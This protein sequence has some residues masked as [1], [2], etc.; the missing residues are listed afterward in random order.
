M[1]CNRR[2]GTLP[3]M[4]KEKTQ[5]IGVRLSLSVLERLKAIGDQMKPLALNQ[6]DMI[7]VA[8]NEYLDNH[9]AE[10]KAKPKK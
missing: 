7:R 2:G 3:R 4:A 1:A 5:Q 8:V 6:S 9:A 10:L